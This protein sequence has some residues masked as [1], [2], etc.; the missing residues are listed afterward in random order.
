MFDIS[1][2]YKISR[3]IASNGMVLLKNSENILPFNS[4]DKIGLVGKNCLNLINGGG[5]SAAV[6]TEYTRSLMDGLVEKTN[7]GKIELYEGT[8]SIAETNDFTINTLNRLANK[9]DT[10]IVVYKRNGNEGGDRRLGEKSKIGFQ[11]GAYAGENSEKTNYDEYE[12]R[13]GY[14]Y[15]SKSELELFSNLQKSNIKNVVLILNIS[16]TVDLSFIEHFSKIKAVLLTYLSGMEIGTAIADVLCG[17]VNPSGRLVDTIAYNYSDYPT[18]DCFDYNTRYTEYKEDIY[19]GYRYF[20]TFAMDRVLYPFGYGLSYTQFQFEDCEYIVDEDNVVISVC[21]KNIGNV[22][23]REVVQIYVKAPE[24]DLPKPKIELKGFAKTE[25]LNPGDTQKVSVSL[26]LKDL[27]SFDDK[28]ILGH[29]SAWVLEKGEYEFFAGK[30]I[31]D[32]VSAGIYNLEENIVTEQLK[33]RLCG[34]KYEREIIDFDNSP[35]VEKNITLYDVKDNK[36]TLKEFINQLSPE[37]M[38]SLSCGQP[39]AFPL[40]TAGV[41]NLKN[42]KIPNSQTADGP[43]GIRRSVNTTCFPCGTLIASCWDSDLQ[44]KMGKAMGVESFSTGIDIILAPSMNLHRNPLCGRNF[45]YFSEDPLITGKTATAIV[46]GIQ[47]QGVCATL[48]HFAVNNCEFWRTTND[49]IV[50]ERALREVYLKGFEIAVNESNPAFIMTSYNR[51]N[52]KYTSE[53]I[54]LLRGV[55]RKEWKYDGAIMTDWRNCASLDNEIIAGNNIKMPYG[56]F[57]QIDIAL[58]AYNKGKLTLADLRNNSYYI[59]NAVMKT[60]RFKENDFGK[61]HVKSEGVLVIPAIEVNGV[62]STRVKQQKRED[63]KDYLFNLGKD[64][65]MQ[66]TFVYY[67]VFVEKEDEYK[68]SAEISTNC[69]S[70]EIWFCNEQDEKLGEVNCNKANNP[71]EWHIVETKI[72]LKAGENVLKLVFADE[73]QRDYPLFDGWFE[74][75]KDD[76][77]I[78]ELVI[79]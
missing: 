64:A 8:V 31:R 58:E 23:G 12:E 78:A 7:E 33:S 5:G 14:F 39:P 50:S 25:N 63:G 49:S 19:V 72:Y 21:V 22:V 20:E 29:K 2:N 71:N 42:R 79:F 57:E 65:R 76:I 13:V 15:P 16:A 34:E 1:E 43:A 9:I 60:K 67:S 28:G 48:K 37:E 70:F 32:L 17:D 74:L 10:A 51:I 44:Y 61:T 59:L 26:K 40:G 41:G 11:E 75:P 68:I 62:S 53:N 54:Q 52:G 69:S 46:N 3:K 56:C 27:A 30:N 47:E 55:L 35:V 73:P 77:Q 38:I 18:S 6:K 66:R 36:V 45:E 24:G 4:N